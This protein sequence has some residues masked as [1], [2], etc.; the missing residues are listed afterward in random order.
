LEGEIRIKIRIR[1]KTMEDDVQRAGADGFVHHGDEPAPVHEVHR[2]VEP[3]VKAVSSGLN[4]IADAEQ[5]H[6]G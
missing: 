1:I 2:P 5:R 6:P 4:L 3:G